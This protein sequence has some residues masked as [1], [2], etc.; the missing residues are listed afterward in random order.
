MPRRSSPSAKSSSGERP[1]P[2]SGDR[3]VRSCVRSMKRIG[4]PTKRNTLPRCSPEPSTTRSRAD[5]PASCTDRA[6]SDLEWVSGHRGLAPRMPAEVGQPPPGSLRVSPDERLFYPVRPHLAGVGARPGASPAIDRIGPTRRPRRWPVM[7]QNWRQ[8]LFLHWAVPAEHV[9]PLV[10]PQL[11]LDLFE[12]TAWVSLVAFTITGLRPVG[13]PPLPGLSS[14]HETNVR[15]YVHR[16]GR[17]PGVWF[18]S[19]DAANRLAV[20]GARLAFHLPYYHARML[21]E[22]LPTS[23][24]GDP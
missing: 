19:L 17:D 16:G 10:P 9:R 5:P 21:L 18:F 14:F 2:P 24:P 7:R 11:D 23:R 13:L 4:R 22:R 3:R 12:D 15:T 20:L 8:L 6:D 1:W